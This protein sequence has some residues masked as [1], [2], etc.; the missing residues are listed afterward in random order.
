MNSI[1]KFY[2]DSKTD[3]LYKLIIGHVGSGHAFRMR[4]DI[5]Y[6]LKHTEDQIIALDVNGE[7][8]KYCEELGGVIVELG[9]DSE[10]FINPLDILTLDISEDIKIDY[11]IALFENLIVRPLSENEKIVLTELCKQYFDKEEAPTL[12][13]FTEHFNIKEGDYPVALIPFIDACKTLSESHLFAEQPSGLYSRKTQLPDFK[14]NRIIVFSTKNAGS[15]YHAYAPSVIAGIWKTV[16]KYY[17]RRK[18]RVY[19]PTFMGAMHPYHREDIGFST[20]LFSLIALGPQNR[21]F[22]VIATIYNYEDFSA[23][24]DSLLDAIFGKNRNNTEVMFMMNTAM[25]IAHMEQY[26]G[27]QYH[28]HNISDAIKSTSYDKV[29]YLYDGS[30]EFLDASSNDAFSRE[31]LKKIRDIDNA[32]RSRM[33]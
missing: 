8:T 11:I 14:D 32:W 3:S 27:K 31:T 9:A 33:N 21:L 29:V 12:L 2:D 16:I 17:R 1:T 7:L 15:Y 4:S 20:S 26:F 28:Y 13:E 23:G 6:N 10:Y 24:E 30:F 22:K 5:L 19:I 25:D 18:C